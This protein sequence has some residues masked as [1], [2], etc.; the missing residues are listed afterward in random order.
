[1]GILQDVFWIK[2][3]KFQYFSTLAR[4]LDWR[5]HKKLH[6]DHPANHGQDQDRI[7]S[8]DPNCENGVFSS[9]LLLFFFFHGFPK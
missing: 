2:L 3:S 9:F 5:L 4:W 8:M 6:I 7:A 1:M